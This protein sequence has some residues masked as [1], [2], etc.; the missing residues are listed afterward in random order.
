[1]TS[2]SK[3]ASK[4]VHGSDHEGTITLLESVLSHFPINI[5]STE[6]KKKPNKR[7]T[8]CSKHNKGSER[9]WQCEKCDVPLH[10]PKC[11][12]EKYHFRRV[13]TFNTLF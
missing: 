11:F 2:V 7:C 4:D 8:V 12:K 3:M 9:C 1:M 6:C 10:I 13:L 5:P